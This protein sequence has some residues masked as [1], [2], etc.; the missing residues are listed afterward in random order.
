MS[1]EK[2]PINLIETADAM[3]WA[4][5]FVRTKLDNGWSL[6]DID[7]SLMVGW[8]AS[9]MQAAVWLQ[10]AAL[11][12][13]LAAA[14]AEN[15]QLRGPYIMQ[16][17]GEE[18]LRKVQAEKQKAIDDETK[19]PWKSALINELVVDHIY[20]VNHET[21]PRKA[22]ADVISWNCRVVLDPSVSKEARD[23]QQQA[24][25]AALESV[26]DLLDS[27]DDWNTGD[28]IAEF[29]RSRIGTNPLAERDARIDEL[30]SLLAEAYADADD[31][32]RP[33]IEELERML[34]NAQAEARR[35]RR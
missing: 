18:T 27:G 13:R 23:L 1:D 10:T 15:E 25:D 21:D 7:E 6:E 33:R 26:A 12:Q 28:E 19:N 3:I 17:F 4:Q 2:K 22:L 9:A 32:L 30:E 24:I 14:E 35:H 20:T 34:A 8:F 16:A 29:I 5:E 31:V 11:E